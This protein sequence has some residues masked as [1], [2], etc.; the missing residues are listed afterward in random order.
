M[1]STKKK[2]FGHR[3]NSFNQSVIQHTLGA[4]LNNLNNQLPNNEYRNMQRKNRKKRM[5]KKGRQAITSG[6][7]RPKLWG[8]VKVRRHASIYFWAS[9]KL[10]PPPTSRQETRPPKGKS[11]KVIHA[12]WMNSMSSFEKNRKL[13]VV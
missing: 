10:R 3:T 2:T 4:S 12:P 6:Q 7:Q 1:I 13:K 5:K 8:N 11:Q 9:G